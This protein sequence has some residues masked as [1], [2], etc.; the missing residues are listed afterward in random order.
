MALATVLS[1]AQNGLAADPVTVEVHLGAGLP[2]VTIVGLPDAA[3]RESRDRVKAAITN[4]GFRFPG[5]RR[6][7]IN[8]APAD[9]PKDGGRFD[10]AM[11]L[12]ILAVS[13]QVPA[14]ALGRCEVLGE[15]ALSGEVRP[16]AGALP[17]ALRAAEAGHALL[18]P[19][20][21]AAEAGLARRARIFA[22]RH[23]G[24]TCAALHARELTPAAP[25]PAIAADEPQPDLG[26]VRGQA[27]AR[28]ALEVAAAGGHS[29]LMVGPPGSGKSMLAQRLPGTLPP[30][31]EDEAI[32][33]AAIASVGLGGFDARR[34]GRRPYRAPHH[35][36]SGVALV[37]GGGQP[38]PGEI[39]LAHHGVLFLD[40][41]PE[42][43]RPVLEVLREPLETG[44]ITVSRAARQADFPARFQLVCAM[45]PCPCG[46][47][48]DSSGKCRCTPDQVHQYR[49][50]ISGPLLDRIDLQIF[51]P[52]VERAVL[53][54]RGAPDGE[55]TA[56]V[57]A[58]V[59]AARE[60]QL[61]RQRKPN[62][63]L[64]PR[65]LERHC[66][67][68]AA[69]SRLLD[70]ALTRLSL[71]ARAYHRV[72]KVART[73]ADLAAADAIAAPHVAEAVRYRELDRDVSFRA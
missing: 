38:R 47:L 29:L 60:R 6:L 48:G 5:T 58:R 50:K 28:R 46:Y 8:L 34:W 19:Q 57:R 49:A 59:I 25:P 65:E 15:L 33:V 62:A 17:A 53:T 1:R 51:V 72:L 30:L 71:S 12:G 26:D 23:L 16:V 61:A 9:L 45:N 4:C 32:E 31:T 27:Q 24:E 14:D 35:T 55:P 36:A 3:V 70:A 68:D 22:A 63:R 18:L 37:G 7:V 56:A 13:E 20:A 67:P 41:M 21:N 52:R 10:L 66:A 54:A 40:E 44:A 42:F 11:A 73:V 2:G 69:A 43:S 39:T 64:A